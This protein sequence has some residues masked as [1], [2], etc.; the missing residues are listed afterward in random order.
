MLYAINKKNISE[1]PKLPVTTPD[2]FKIKEKDIENFLI[3]NLN[4]VLPEDQ[5]MII[6]QERSYQEEADI[7]AIDKT[8]KLY[9][10]ELKRWES[11]KEN[12][13]Q[14]L[15]YGQ[16]FGRY[17]YSELEDLFHRQLN[18]KGALKDK[19]K[20]YFE[21]KE[22]LDEQN[23]NHDQSFVLIT[24]GIDRDTLSAIAYWR[25]K[26]VTI[27]CIPYKIYNIDDKPYIQFETYNP[28]EE[29][30]IEQDTQ[31]FIAN[32][33]KTYMPDIW[34]EMIGDGET[35]KAAAYYDRKRRTRRIKK[36]SIV[37]LYHNST[38]V[39]AKGVATKDYQKLEF[40]GEK[41]AEFSVPLKF[42]WALTNKKSWRSNAISAR[43]INSAMKSN[44]CFRQTVFSISEDMAKAIDDLYIQNNSKND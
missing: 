10:F 31:Y 4:D 6:G 30:L 38:G 41:N 23:F 15:R 12:L 32:T 1:S 42:E 39:I 28:E 40:D 24:C 37:Y 33:N 25:D 43:Q 44:Q 17:N 2:Q 7:L 5:L 11:N 21:L 35:G 29:L 9:I 16:I 27:D 20:E 19:H 26:G 22:T 14:V 34:K 3:T 8:G 13:L 18:V 36:K